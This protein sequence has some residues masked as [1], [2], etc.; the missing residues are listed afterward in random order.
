M[1]GIQTL[2]L[3]GLYVGAQLT[4]L[5]LAQPFIHAG[6]VTNST[7][8][9]VSDIL[10]FLI[11]IVAIPIVIIAI[12]KFAP[13]NINVI[14]FFILFAICLSLIFT[15]WPTFDLVL[16]SPLDLA[17]GYLT[18]DWGF[19]LGSLVTGLV[20]LALLLEPQWY[21]VDTVGYLAAGGLTAILGASLG[22]LPVMILLVA[23]LCYDA[24]AV[25]GTKHMLTLADAVSDMKLPIMLVMPSSPQF[26]YTA[27]PS[28]KETRERVK[29][30]PQE[31]EA[32]FMGLGDIV[33]PGVLVVSAF[34]FLPSSVH[35]LGLGAN[36][37]VAFAA[38]AGS[39]LGYGILMVL[40]SRGNAQAGL[41]FLN[42]FGILGYALAYVLIFHSYTLGLA[43]PQL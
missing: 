34:V 1:R 6:L 28:L 18:V 37:I 29:A 31:R 20:F 32:T 25:Y 2:G 15:T 14:K 40:V 38:M 17:G 5:A 3:L 13:K 19:Y 36:L 23:L 16:P 33:I 8:N 35:L 39:L 43:V 9:S 24:I 41:P 11:A 42:G 10:P 27:A 21:V 22:I 30:A 4:A 7:P 26:D 12:F